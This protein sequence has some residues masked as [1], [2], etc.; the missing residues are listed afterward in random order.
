MRSVTDDDC[1]AS[2]AYAPDETDQQASGGDRPGL[3]AEARRALARELRR[4]APNVSDALVDVSLPVQIIDRNGI[5]RWQNP[6]S[7]ELLGTRVGEHF[8]SFVPSDAQLQAR[9]QFARKLVGGVRMTSYTTRV[10]DRDGRPREAEV[11]TIRLGDEHSAVGV[12]GVLKAQRLADGDVAHPRLTSRQQEVLRLLAQGATTDAIANE[13][14]ITPQTVRNHVRNVLR[15]L[16][17]H[18]RVQAVVRAHELGI[19]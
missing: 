8:V 14:H 18:S 13:L 17:V 3:P 19:R 7:T 6:A 15:G 16:G 10:L 11:E 4:I 12:F 1:G 9:Q 2:R 5:V